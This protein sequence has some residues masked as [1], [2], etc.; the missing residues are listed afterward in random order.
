MPQAFAAV[1]NLYFSAGISL[2]SLIGLLAWATGGQAT[3]LSAGA[4]SFSD[5]LGGFRILSVS[6]AGTAADPIE[7]VEEVDEAA[8]ITLVIRRRIPPG[9]PLRPDYAPLTL[10][11]VV[12]NRSQRVWAGF[13]VEL[14]EILSRP[15]NYGD[16]LSFNQ[17]GVR[18]PDAG[19][20]A[21]A[22]NDRVFEPQD[23]IRFHNGSVDP[24]A[25]VRF[26][27]T[28]TDPTPVAE[29]YLVQDPQLLSAGLPARGSLAGRLD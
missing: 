27:L 6:G 11:K 26:K 25:T 2:A 29:F 7:I 23:R 18:P 5:E 24:G 3:E 12:V 28:I 16:G 22:D 13:D 4:Y 19:S 20:D 10:V 21:F 17:F 8:P 9:S 15:S 14:Q 1:R